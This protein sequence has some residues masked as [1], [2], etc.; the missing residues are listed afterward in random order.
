MIDIPQVLYTTVLGPQLNEDAESLRRDMASLD[1]SRTRKV[2]P[3]SRVGQL[4][5]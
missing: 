5:H 1:S 4:S 2:S 3:L